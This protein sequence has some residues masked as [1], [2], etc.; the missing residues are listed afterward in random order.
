MLADIGL[1]AASGANKALTPAARQ[2]LDRAAI[3]LSTTGVPRLCAGTAKDRGLL[4]GELPKRPTAP[5]PVRFNIYSDNW[6]GYGIDGNEFG[7]AINAAEGAWNVGHGTTSGTTQYPSVA[8][9]TWVG[10]G[11]L[12]DI[13]T[14]GLI[15][16]GVFIVT[17]PRDP[18]TPAGYTSWIEVISGDGITGCSVANNN[19]N[20]IFNAGDSTRPGDRMLVRSYY[21]SS[22][23]ACFV[24]VDYTHSSGSIPPACEPPAVYDHTS[25]EWIN[26]SELRS[27]YLYNN[28]GTISFNTQNVS[29]AFG[30][31]SWHQAFTGQYQTVIMETD[32]IDH[33][34]VTT[35]PGNGVLLSK[36]VNASGSASQIATYG[37]NG[38]DQ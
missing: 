33:D 12:D 4:G 6:G 37:V 25:G 22:R 34:G 30:G 19:C 23:Q 5:S 10:V 18:V 35:C 13:G 21:T 24:V 8:E 15:Q 26:E 17:D 16:A 9:T 11:G 29:G 3:A 27:H 2:S 38:C 31:G 28:P 20:P 1:E 36:G 14:T 32:V 7:G